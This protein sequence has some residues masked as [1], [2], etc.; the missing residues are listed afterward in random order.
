M[1]KVFG[2]VSF[3]VYP[4]L[5]GGQKGVALFYKHL[6]EHANIFL[7]LSFDNGEPPHVESIN[8][9]Y[10]NKQIYRNYSRIA[11][12]TKQV[13]HIQPDIIIAE[14]SYTGWI[15]WQL[16]RKTGV[17]LIIHSHNIESKRFQQMGKWWWRLYAL[18]EGWIHRKAQYNFFISE[19]DKAYALQHFKLDPE[20]CSV[21]T[22]GI[23]KPSIRQDRT[24][25]R[26]KLGL[27]TEETVLLFNGTLDYEPN[28]E[29]VQHLV[30]RI[31]PILSKSLSNYIIVVTGNRAPAELVQLMAESRNV[32]YH[33][34]VDDVNEY[35]QAADLFINPVSN[36]TG[37]K[38]K[39]IEAVANHCTSLSTVSG[40]TGIRRDVCGNKLV[41]VADDDWHAFSHAIVNL[42]KTDAGETP[43]SFYDHYEWS[44][45]AKKAAEKMEALV[46]S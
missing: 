3:R 37:V 21:V 6:Q 45:I 13:K 9:L 43:P 25:L 15:G 31:E 1:L 46:K 44:N 10:P 18:Y 23:E 42:L 28:Y 16:H 33:G 26:K 34:Y 27:P 24:S 38:T 35:Y 29:A 41:T 20:E 2:L 36:D 22:Y 39:L 32:V 14:H 8:N 19:E 11:A 12:L 7:A 17:P 4:T 5:M 30:K 40:A